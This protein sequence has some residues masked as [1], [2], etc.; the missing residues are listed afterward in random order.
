[1]LCTGLPALRKA[2][3]TADG[4]AFWSTWSVLMMNGTLALPIA[5]PQTLA[6]RRISRVERMVWR[7]RSRSSVDDSWIRILVG[8]IMGFKESPQYESTAREQLSGSVPKF[9]IVHKIISILCRRIGQSEWASVLGAMS[10]EWKMLI[11][12]VSKASVQSMQKHQFWKFSSVWMVPSLLWNEYYETCVMQNRE[13]VKLEEWSQSV[14]E[15]YRNAG[16]WSLTWPSK[17]SQVLTWICS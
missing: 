3:P 8:V 9:I 15:D 5:A 12:P 14:A 4:W 10:S 11:W 1:M 16:S 17:V 6:S 7:C 2:T 13:L